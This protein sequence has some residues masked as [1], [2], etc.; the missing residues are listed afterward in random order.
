MTR[1]EKEKA[2]CAGRAAELTAEMEAAIKAG[3]K[4]RFEKAYQTGQRYMTK[5]QLKPLY[6]RFLNGRKPNIRMK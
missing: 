2:Y 6:M 1:W 3:D 5:K 4:A